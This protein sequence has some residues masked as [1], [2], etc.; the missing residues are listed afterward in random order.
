MMGHFK[1]RL[2][3][4]DLDGR[5]FQLTKDFTYIDNDGTAYTVPKGFISD[6]SSVPRIL[7]SIVSP[8]GRAKEP[9]AG[10]DFDYWVAEIPRKAAD[11]KYRRMLNVKRFNWFIRWAAYRG[12]R[13]GAW[14]HYNKKQDTMLIDGVWSTRR[15]GFWMPLIREQFTGDKHE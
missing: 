13:T 15:G 9:G 3:S 7:W 8:K 5:W 1:D 12:L 11:K 10:H 4:V 14:M 2:H 6:G